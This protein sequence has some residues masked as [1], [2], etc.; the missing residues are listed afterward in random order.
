MPKRKQTPPDRPGSPGPRDDGL[1][2]LEQFAAGLIGNG[3]YLIPDHKILC[4]IRQP[5]RSVVAIANPSVSEGQ[6]ISLL[7]D[8]ADA[9]ERQTLA[10]G[11][12]KLVIETRR[13]PKTA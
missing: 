11:N 6:I 13:P 7:R 10:D 2:P 5:D 12:F 3:A 4:L 8:I 9:F 1:T